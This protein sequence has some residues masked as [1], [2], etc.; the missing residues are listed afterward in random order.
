MNSDIVVGDGVLRIAYREQDDRYAHRIILSAPQ[1]DMTLL[2]SVE[3]E[4]DVNWPA[5][6]PLQDFEIEP[7]GAG[8]RVALM[9]GMAGTGHWS[10]SVEVEKKFLRF[11]IA[12][13]I[14][15]PAKSLGSTYAA[16]DVEITLRDGAALIETPASLPSVELLADPDGSTRFELRDENQLWIGPDGETDEL[17]TTVRWKYSLRIGGN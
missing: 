10:A 12:C 13:R 1:E 7:R 11:D 9:V 14:R 5:S 4:P 17:P 15:E 16:P 8:Q 3:S 6:P 2:E